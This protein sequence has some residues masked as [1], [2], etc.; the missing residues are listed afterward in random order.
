MAAEELSN[1]FVTFVQEIDGANSANEARQIC[2]TFFAHLVDNKMPQMVQLLEW[3]AATTL[4]LAQFD[5]RFYCWQQFYN[6]G[7]ESSFWVADLQD[8]MR[9]V[10]VDIY[11][12]AL[13]GGAEKCIE[14]F[15]SQGDIRSAINVFAWVIV[16][17]HEIFSAEEIAAL[18]KM[19]GG[20]E[21]VVTFPQLPEF[22]DGASKFI[23]A[24]AEAAELMPFNVAIE[25]LAQ[26][27]FEKEYKKIDIPFAAVTTKLTD[28][29]YA[30]KLAEMLMTTDIQLVEDPM[31]LETV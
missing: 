12:L 15:L 26:S 24:F 13:Y 16:W 3:P 5:A 8:G 4:P 28:I 6:I 21:T 25:F 11:G 9:T 22:Y 29:I 2:N 17:Y 14:H 19:F 18:V 30:R 1:R 20:D 23:A 7:R 10:S 31:R 27:D